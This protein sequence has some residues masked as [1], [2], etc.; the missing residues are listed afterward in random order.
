M[1][2]QKVSDCGMLLT[3][4]SDDL[5]LSA[6][7][8]ERRTYTSVSAEQSNWNERK[9][10]DFQRGKG[11]AETESRQPLIPPENEFGLQLPSPHVSC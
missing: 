8:S 3:T 9:R 11:R 5:A 2:F 1:M 10:S 4:E 7:K 6:G